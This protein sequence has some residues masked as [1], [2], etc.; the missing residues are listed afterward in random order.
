MGM[1]P[2]SLATAALLRLLSQLRLG[3]Y[4]PSR[5]EAI[6]LVQHPLR[7]GT[8][9]GSRLLLRIRR[10]SR[11]GRIPKAQAALSNSRSRRLVRPARR[12]CCRDA[13]RKALDLR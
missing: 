9:A 10:R 4:L 12:K 2:I 11:S 8:P 13:A 7:N 3:A 1:G 6:L 5:L